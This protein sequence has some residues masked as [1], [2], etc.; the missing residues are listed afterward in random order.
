MFIAVCL[1]VCLFVTIV[2]LLLTCT[3]TFFQTLLCSPLQQAKN[4][5]IV[6]DCITTVFATMGKPV[7]A[8]L[9]A[10]A[11]PP[12]MAMV[13]ARGKL[14]LVALECLAEIAENAKQGVAPF[15]NETVA[16][17][18]KLLEE[19]HRVSSSLEES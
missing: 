7:P 10:L 5:G 3:L 2:V 12:V 18:M 11:C 15:A 1:F 17:C 9:V 13:K 6:M 8:D 14:C 16:C 19:A 4:K